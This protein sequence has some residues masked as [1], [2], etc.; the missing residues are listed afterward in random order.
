MEAQ[1]EK[2]E[3]GTWGKE[4]EEASAEASLTRRE[5]DQ[6]EERAGAFWALGSKYPGGHRA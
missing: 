5:S 6:A 4:A 2:M 3:Q 1:L